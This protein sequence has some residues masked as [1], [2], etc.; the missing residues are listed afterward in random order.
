MEQSREWS[1]P[2]THHGVIAIEKGAFGSPT[3]KTANL[4]FILFCFQIIF[5]YPLFL[6]ASIFNLFC[7]GFYFLISLVLSFCSYISFITSL[8]YLHYICSYHFICFIILC[9]FFNIIQY[10]FRNIF[11]H[12]VKHFYIKEKIR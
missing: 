2:P 8:L 10:C 5:Y 11:H 4:P 1:N 3:T 7:F 12:T 9:H 6:F